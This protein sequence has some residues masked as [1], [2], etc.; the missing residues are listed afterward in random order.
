MG[1]GRG[2]GGSVDA[3]HSMLI[4]ANLQRY[5]LCEGEG[6]RRGTDAGATV[7]QQGES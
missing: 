2:E 1:G 4:K 5:I 6:V 7:G 3:S